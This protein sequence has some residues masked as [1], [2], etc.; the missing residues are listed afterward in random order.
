MIAIG[1]VSRNR[2]IFDRLL[3]LRLRSSEQPE[4]GL[5]ACETTVRTNRHN[6]DAFRSLIIQLSI[7]GGGH[8]SVPNGRPT[9][10]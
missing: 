8:S 1:L 6:R 4:R 9:V 7:L 5:A 10:S 2:G 3:Y